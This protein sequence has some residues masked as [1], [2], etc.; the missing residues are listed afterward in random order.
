VGFQ[1]QNYGLESFDYG[2]P[3]FV[4]RHRYGFSDHVSGG[5]RLELDRMTGS[6]GAEVTLG[7][8]FGQLDF[9]TALSHSGETGPRSGAA[10]LAGYG[11]SRR[12]VALRVLVRGT[13]RDYCTLSLRPEDDRS[14][15]EQVTSTSIAI[16]QGSFIGAQVVYA[17][18]RDTGQT[19]RLSLRLTTR[20]SRE[21]SL[22]VVSSRTYQGFGE[23]YN[24]LFATLSIALPWRHRATVTERSTSDGEEVSAR[25]SRSIKGHSGV[26]YQ[27]NAAL[28][29]QYRAGATV[30]GRSRF[31]TVEANYF[32]Y[33][34]DQHTL[35]EAASG[36]VVVPSAGDEGCRVSD[37]S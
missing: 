36:L 4:G 28:S 5:L 8:E 34:G 7:G 3:A 6:G 15:L 14:L 32:N 11:Y 13:S 24:D 26:G 20:L 21:L 17:E 16:G 37:L 30:Q 9:A 22:R 18:A 1:R 31:G 27:V 33:D 2:R 25:L 12:G 23:W 35:V 29:E 19:A 10:A